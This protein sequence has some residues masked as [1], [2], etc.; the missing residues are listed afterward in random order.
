MSSQTAGSLCSG[1]VYNHNSS[2]PWYVLSASL[3][4]L[5]LLFI[6]LVEEPE[7]AEV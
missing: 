7:E 5:G 2:L 3:F 4:T 6:I 1:Y